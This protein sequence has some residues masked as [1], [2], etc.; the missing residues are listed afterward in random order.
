MKM[1]YCLL[2][3][4]CA[5][6][7]K[8]AR[9]E[10]GKPLGIGD[11]VPNI[12]FTDIL[13]SSKPTANLYDFKS[14]LVLIDFWATH[15]GACIHKFPMLDSMKKACKQDLNILLVNNSPHDT[16]EKVGKLF[17]RFR[18][19]NGI[20][21]SL[22][23]VL[24]DTTLDAMFPHNYIPH[25]VW[26][27]STFTVIAITGTNE[28]NA[29]RI[30]DFIAGK[31]ISFL[32]AEMLKGFNKH[33]PLFINGNGGSGKQLLYRS[34]VS[35]YI[36][37]LPSATYVTKD[38]AGLVKQ[39]LLTNQP[40]LEFIKTA[41][42]YFEYPPRFKWT[43]EIQEELDWEGRKGEWFIENSYCY[44][45]ITKPIPYEKALLQIREDIQRYFG[46]RAQIRNL[47]TSCYVIHTDS[48]LLKRFPAK[49]LKPIQDPSAKDKPV[50]HFQTLFD[51]AEFLN[52]ILPLPVVNESGYTK[53]VD[54]D[55]SGVSAQDIELIK[56]ALARYGIYIT[57]AKRPLDQFFIYHTTNQY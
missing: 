39:I 31:P 21:L 15:C 32:D 38:T 48:I 53:P 18:N 55:I 1:I 16:R 14:K 36:P 11:K 6:Y 57:E 37:G 35:S 45:L 28:V 8:G 47:V 22:P 13:N 54:I 20:A 30:S 4:L 7:C 52:Q 12:H 26:L 10:P 56:K 44:E 3:L 49:T 51:C 19:T 29:I 40:I 27:D 25:Y 41:F 34:T 5:Y 46:Y 17:D 43:P 24:G 2:L 50:L 42:Q 33:L 9:A 23:V